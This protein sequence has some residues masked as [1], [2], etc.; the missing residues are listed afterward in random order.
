MH[1]KAP[2]DGATLVEIIAKWNLNLSLWGVSHLGQGKLLDCNQIQGNVT[3]QNWRL[4]LVLKPWCLGPGLV[5]GEVWSV[6]GWLEVGQSKA[7]VPVNRLTD[8]SK[9]IT[10][11]I[12]QNV[13]SNN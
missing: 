11:R 3:G 10:F 12:L 6:V 13:V 4:F 5:G 7:G 9:N 2:N 8:R 1:K